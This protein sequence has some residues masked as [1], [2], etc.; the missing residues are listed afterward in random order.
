MRWLQ[1]Q[2]GEV[3]DY[4]TASNIWLRISNKEYCST[5]LRILVNSLGPRKPWCNFKS[6]A[7]PLAIKSDN[8]AEYLRR[9][10]TFDIVSI[11][12]Q[13]QLQ[14]ARE[15]LATIWKNYANNE[16]LLIIKHG[17]NLYPRYPYCSAEMTTSKLT[18][19][20]IRWRP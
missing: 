1:V 13:L 5:T 12:W 8:Y 9:A 4:T 16:K 19:Q 2:P 20:K 10:I 14:I 7:A 17:I 11:R 3:D 6:S 15:R 18:A